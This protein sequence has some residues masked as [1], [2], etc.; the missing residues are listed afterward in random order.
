VDNGGELFRWW[1][2]SL[3]ALPKKDKPVAEKTT[4]RACY[5]GLV[6]IFTGWIHTRFEA[7]FNLTLL[8][9]PFSLYWSKNHF[10]WFTFRVS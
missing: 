8:L 1:A 9:T 2:Q 10:F 7:D 6:K 5:K 4:R 3:D